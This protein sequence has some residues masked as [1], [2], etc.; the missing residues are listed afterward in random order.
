MI[1]FQSRMF[2]IV[3]CWVLAPYRE[4]SPE[5]TFRRDNLRATPKLTTSK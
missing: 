2:I 4:N 5:R 3:D 1:V